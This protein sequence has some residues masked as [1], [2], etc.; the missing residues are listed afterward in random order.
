MV[1]SRFLFKYIVMILLAKLAYKVCYFV[2][3]YSYYSKLLLY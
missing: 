1:R 3:Y 2:K